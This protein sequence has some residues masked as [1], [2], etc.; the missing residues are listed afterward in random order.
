MKAVIPLMIPRLIA[1]AWLAARQARFVS[2][3][4]VGDVRMISLSITVILVPR[5]IGT[6]L[7]ITLRSKDRLIL[8][9]VG[10]RIRVCTGRKMVHL[11]NVSC[12]ILFIYDTLIKSHP[13][14]S[15]IVSRTLFIH[16]ED[17]LGLNIRDV[18]SNVT[19]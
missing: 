10:P 8:T 4:R 11:L 1:F 5:M 13:R 6:A 3:H 7:R 18:P 16:P 12:W 9:K 14:R 19:V 2:R 17:Q 15:I